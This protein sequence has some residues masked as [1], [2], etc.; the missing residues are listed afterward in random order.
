[1]C[2]S[3]SDL[4]KV[5]QSLKSY[6]PNCILNSFQRWKFFGL[7]PF[8][9]CVPLN[10]FFLYQIRKFFVK[11]PEN[12]LKNVPKDTPFFIHGFRTILALQY[13]YH[14]THSVSNILIDI[15]L[16]HS[17]QLY[18]PFR[19]SWKAAM[20]ICH[21]I[22]K[23]ISICHTSI[24]VRDW[25]HC[26]LPQWVWLLQLLVKLFFIDLI[27]SKWLSDWCTGCKCGNDFILS[28]W[29]GSAQ[30]KWWRKC[31]EWFESEWNSQYKHW[32]WCFINQ[33]YGNANSWRQCVFQVIQFHDQKIN[34]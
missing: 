11:R 28:K 7:F 12:R 8:Y 15:C 22:S 16:N 18:W 14:N 33:F 32:S 30:I 13:V 29:W 10:W 34:R 31:Y 4:S 3:C 2:W 20:F 6:W 1:M 24:R 23:R 9:S 27:E 26:H 21:I 19:C 25:F 5:K 17:L